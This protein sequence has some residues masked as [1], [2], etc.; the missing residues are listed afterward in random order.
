MTKTYRDAEARLEAAYRRLG[1][2]NP[3]C[4]ICGETHPHSL[5]RHHL[6]GQAQHEDM[7][8]VCRNC[9]RRLSDSQYDRQISDT[10]Q[11]K[12]E[13]VGHYLMGLADLF[14]MLAERLA[15]FGTWLLEAA[16]EPE[17]V[18]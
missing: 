18:Q 7:A 17:A 2:R 12:L 13:T 4:V 6:A 11:P 14:A 3:S 16:L 5:E 8:I 9:H 1:T 10:A 15:E